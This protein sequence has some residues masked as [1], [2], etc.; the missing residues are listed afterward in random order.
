MRRRRGERVDWVGVED[1]WRVKE[2]RIEYGYTGVLS[3]ACPALAAV[4]LGQVWRAR[5][6][7]VLHCDQKAGKSLK[8]GRGS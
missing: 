4:G 7:G 3:V 5:Q 8:D 1:K 6:V 2:L